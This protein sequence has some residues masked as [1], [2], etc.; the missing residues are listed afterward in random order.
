MSA[1][2]EECQRQSRF[3]VRELDASGQGC[4]I[5]YAAGMIRRTECRS[6]EVRN[7]WSSGAGM[8]WSCACADDGA[9]PCHTALARILAATVVENPGAVLQ[10][11]HM[12]A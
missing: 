8:L 1:D 11:L 10:R 4:V 6:G 2:S 7:A 5:G 3:G 9:H 12:S